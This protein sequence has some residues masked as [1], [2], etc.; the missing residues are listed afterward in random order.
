M[1][2]KPSTDKTRAALKN[3]E[4]WANDEIS[5]LEKTFA[6]QQRSDDTA[7]GVSRSRG[8]VAGRALET[9]KKS[10]FAAGFFLGLVSGLALAALIILF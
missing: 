6:D 10:G 9:L 5:R 8:S 3:L 7:T 1:S 4:P 2:D